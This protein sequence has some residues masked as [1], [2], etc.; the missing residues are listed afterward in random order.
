MNMTVENDTCSLTNGICPGGNE[1]LMDLNLFYIRQIGA[2]LKKHV[3]IQDKLEKEIKLRDGASRMLAACTH[4]DQLLEVAKTLHTSNARMYS[5]MAELQKLKTAEIME[6]VMDDEGIQNESKVCSGRVAISDIR[7][8]LMWNDPERYIGAKVKEASRYAVFCLVHVGGEVQDTELVCTDKTTTDVGFRDVLVFEE[9][10]HNF[11]MEIE[12]HAFPMSEGSISAPTPQKLLARLNRSIGK[13]EG[14]RIR[15]RLKESPS[16]NMNMG[17]QYE[18]L[19]KL[20]LDL[21]SVDDHIRS[22][23]I[24]RVA[25]TANNSGRSKPLLPLYGSLTCRLVA[26][27][28]CITE[29]SITGFL[30][31]ME[32][33]HGMPCWSY[34][35]CEVRAGKLQCWLNP[36]DVAEK[37]PQNSIN[38]IAS[39][40]KINEIEKNRQ[41]RPN[42]FQV[43]DLVDRHIFSSSCKD[44]MTK[45]IKNLRQ[46]RSDYAAWSIACVREKDGSAPMYIASPSPY[47]S[48][49]HMLFDASVRK[50]LI[51][52]QMSIESPTSP[53]FGT[54]AVSDMLQKADNTQSDSVGV[55][56]VEANQSTPWA[57]LFSGAINRSVM[58]VTKLKDVQNI[59]FSN[60]QPAKKSSRLRTK[61]Y[62]DNISTRSGSGSSSSS[63]NKKDRQKPP[64]PQHRSFED[65]NVVKLRVKSPAPTKPAP[66]IEDLKS[67]NS[68]SCSETGLSDFC[69][70]SDDVFLSSDENI[71]NSPTRRKKSPQNQTPNS[72]TKGRKKR[73]APQPPSSATQLQA[74][75]DHRSMNLRSRSK[76]SLSSASSLDDILENDSRKTT[77]H[78]S[79]DSFYHHFPQPSPRLQR[80][81][82]IYSQNS[83]PEGR[84]SQLSLISN[85][86]QFS[87]TSSGYKSDSEGLVTTS[88]RDIISSKQRARYEVDVC[89]QQVKTNPIKKT[90][91]KVLPTNVPLG[92]KLTPHKFSRSHSWDAEAVLHSSDEATRLRYSST[93]SSSRNGISSKPPPLPKPNSV[94]R[95]QTSKNDKLVMQMLSSKTLE[96]PTG[97]RP[98]FPRPIPAPRRSYLTAVESS[99][100]AT[101]ATS[102]SDIPGSPA[103]RNNTQDNDSDYAEVDDII[104]A[105]PIPKELRS[106]NNN[107]AVH[108]KEE[109]VYAEVDKSKKIKNRAACKNT[110]EKSRKIG[111]DAYTKAHKAIITVCKQRMEEQEKIER[112]HSRSDEE[113]VYV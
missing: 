78:N 111:V 79:T 49:S 83:D 31:Y 110:N 57:G 65:M 104:Y 58:R 22:H 76:A 47:K 34:M 75:T 24:T 41:K 10:A 103:I 36:E 20:A 94:P 88:S 74:E 66:K 97:L 53:D 43:R 109:P 33:G 87:T 93:P 39:D 50:T 72:K 7:I 27:P 64:I 13:S 95:K 71:L 63:K 56:M 23:D 38:L 26:Q 1:V 106:V 15:D 8:P 28:K 113:T 3:G 32:V 51:Y 102:L 52:E 89:E 59:E 16:A 100:V 44:D 112:K 98:P 54:V 101:K 48:P 99:K 62:E 46:H 92:I 9:T 14:K 17:P 73:R 55:A 40:I 18:K 35:W 67:F 68:E 69:Q 2:S 12:I 60:P 86:T 77:Q 80:L 84:N 6:R 85:S 25:P 82:D 107:N 11:K 29:K 42:S 37:T 108:L 91:V 4:E 61:S 96:S 19:G 21:T 105:V 5:Y 90:G 81:N 30:H 45:W 70:S